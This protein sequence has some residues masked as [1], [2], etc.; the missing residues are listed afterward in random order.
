M[1]F[2][3]CP[4]ASGSSGN[5]TYVAG[6]RTAILVDAGLSARETERRLGLIGV[7]IRSIE[8][9]CLT[10]E[11]GDHIT[12]LDVLH[13]RL[14]MKLYA[15]SGTIEA[16]GTVSGGPRLAWNVFSNGVPFRIGDLDLEPFSVPHD[17]YDP[18]GFV[19]HCGDVRAGIV[20]DM[21]TATTLVRER[22]K[23]CQVVILESNHDE[24]MLK[25]AARPWAVKQ[26]I[27]GRQGHLS[28]AAAAELI[29]DI[30]GPELTHVYLAHLSADCNTPELALKALADALGRRGIRHVALKVAPRDG[31]SDVWSAD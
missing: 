15:N 19:V 28:N 3:I 1:S 2:R 14:G 11:H 7:D 17:A 20:T 22:L 26:R 25:D 31:I 6:D 27:F 5:C 4:L 21:G 16:I 12:G 30:A 29:A 9:V 23:G 8:A 10:H 24:R 18:V 13:R